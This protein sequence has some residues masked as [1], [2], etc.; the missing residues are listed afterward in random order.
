MAKELRFNEEARRLLVSG[1]DKRANAGRVTLGPMGRNAMLERLAGPPTIINDGVTIAREIQIP[2][3]F[4]NM[5]A[6]L[7]KEV[8][9]Q[10]NEVAGDGT[11]TA[12]VLAQ[13]IVTEGMT[14]VQQG[15]NPVLL[16]RG[17]EAAVAAVVE[18]LNRAARP[19]ESRAEMQQI[20]T[21]SANN[22]PAIGEVIAEAMDRVGRD[23]FISV[24]QSEA[25]GSSSSSPR[26]SSSTTA[27]C[28]RTWSPTPGGW[29][30]WS[31]TPTSCS[32]TRPSPWSRS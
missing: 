31:R 32:A 6:Q 1:V 3:P 5:G 12:T 18:A 14:R 4:E 30:R 9:N 11:T 7:V 16:K 26:A 13:A 19:V 10:T 15:G 23:A 17:I 24:E 29:R 25:F 8:A 20:A 21:I 2:D 28:P 27:T 22:D